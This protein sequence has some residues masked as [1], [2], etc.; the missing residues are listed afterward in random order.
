M[1]DI[2][3]RESELKIS[4]LYILDHVYTSLLA[5]ED[6]KIT[7]NIGQN[8]TILVNILQYHT[9]SDNISRYIAILD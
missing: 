9:I 8:V 2:F 5:Y 4:S 1:V 7:D 6:L 3:K